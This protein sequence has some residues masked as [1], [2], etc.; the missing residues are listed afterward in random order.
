M[1]LDLDIGL[2]QF[3]DNQGAL[4][5][6]EA[7]PP[8]QPQGPTQT[9]FLRSSSE[10][11]QESSESAEAPAH[12]RKA[13]PKYLAMDQQTSLRNND[14]ASWNNNYVANMADAA[15]A[16][17]QHKVAALAKKNAAFFVYGTGI[18]GVGLGLGGSK[19]PS[20]LDMFAGDQLMTALTGLEAAPTGR[21]RSFAEEEE[22]HDSDS[23]GRRVRA[24]EDDGDLVG[25]GDQMALDEEDTMGMGM[26]MQGED[27]RPH[28]SY[29]Q[30]STF[31]NPFSQ[32]HRNRP[33]RR[34]TP[35]RLLLPNALEH[36]RLRSRFSRRL[37]RPR[38]SRFHRRVRLKRRSAWICHRPRS[39]FSSLSRPPQPPYLCQ[40][41]SRPRP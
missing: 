27:V 9:G 7:F 17:Q 24:R 35:R 37:H 41:P 32:G 5:E 22:A 39:A 1:N 23:E 30:P 26:G 15:Q 31:T 13:A 12:R 38:P 20:P 40:P 34:P 36:Y 8:M 16:K 19:L 21:K 4:P 6:A 2:P 28:L 14:L 33:P 29:N 10:V 11:P 18:G 25:R 3:D